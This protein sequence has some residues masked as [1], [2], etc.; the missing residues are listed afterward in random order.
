MKPTIVIP[1]GHFDGGLNK[2]RAAPLIGKNEGQGVLNCT[3]A[4][5]ELKAIAAPTA[6]LTNLTATDITA[7]YRYGTGETSASFFG[8]TGTDYS[9]IVFDKPARTK[10]AF[11][12]ASKALSNAQVFASSGGAA[13][14]LAQ[15]A[16]A[17]PSLTSSAG[18]FRNL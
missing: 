13:F 8:F 18:G 6:L 11:F 10:T 5:G 3:I 17:A 4:N 16:P 1:F 14:D 9:G 15:P 2:A 12:Y 7:L